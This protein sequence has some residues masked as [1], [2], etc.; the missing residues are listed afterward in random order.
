MVL[1]LCYAFIGLLFQRDMAWRK[2]GSLALL[3]PGAWIAIQG[4]RPLSY[5]FGGGGGSEANPIDTA[6]FAGLIG[7]AIVVL[8]KRGLDWRGLVRQNKVLFLIYFYLLLSTFWSEMPFISLKR[9]F[10]DFGCVL[11]ALV[12]LTEKNP[13]E[14][15]RAVFVRVS[16]ILFPLSVVF[17]KFFPQ[18]GR[19][20]TRAGEN[21]FTGVAIHKNSLGE[22]LFVFMLMILWDLVETY[23]G[24]DRR[25][26]KGQVLIRLGMFL[27]GLSLLVT[28]DSQTSLV[29]LIL[30][31]VVFWGSGR[32]VRMPHGKRVL[33]ACLVSVVCLKT[34]DKTFGIS[35]T[36]AVALGRNPTLTG[37]TDIWRIVL[38]QKTNPAIGSGFYTFWDSD[39]G[40][41]VVESLMRINSAHNGY[42]EL[43]LDAGLVGDALLC[44]LLLTVGSRAIDRLFAGAPLGRMS[45]IFWII[46][47]FYNLSETSFFRLDPLWFTF[48]LIT[49][50]CQRRSRK[51]SSANISHETPAF[52]TKRVNFA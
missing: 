9:L 2:A 35:D 15:V 20:S 19:Q 32:L 50:Q 10:K 6:A 25:G 49:I 17:I 52:C 22:T 43:Y 11:V 37:R 8:L 28:C 47:I 39:K 24:E 26:K 41:T 33:I 45:L 51:S 1:L 27:M 12:F 34:V 40:K 48:L 29:C 31:G 30:G 14:A 13:A 18:I 7:S 4:S 44:V 38:D 3:I 42:L 5:W 16:Y 46:A 21:M 23:K 36:I